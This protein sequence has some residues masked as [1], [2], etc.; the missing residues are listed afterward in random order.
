MSEMNPATL[1]AAKN[2]IEKNGFLDI[3]PDPTLD[4]FAEIERLKK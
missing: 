4:L 1:A 3:E 2:E